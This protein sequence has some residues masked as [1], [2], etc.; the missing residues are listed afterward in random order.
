[1]S[2]NHECP[3]ASPIFT[4]PTQVIRNFYYPQIQ[5]V[6]HPVEIINRHHCVPIPQHMVACCVKD[7]VCTISSRNGNSR[8]SDS[9]ARV[10]RVKKKK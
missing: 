9:K 10:S 2:Y 6:I 5:P 1:L 3:Q 4:D 8:N 7:E